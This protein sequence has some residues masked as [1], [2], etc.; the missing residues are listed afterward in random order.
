MHYTSTRQMVLRSI[1]QF[2][3]GQIDLRGQKHHIIMIIKIKTK[4]KIKQ[5]FRLTVPYRLPGLRF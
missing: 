3:D 5:K 4:N 1:P 2:D